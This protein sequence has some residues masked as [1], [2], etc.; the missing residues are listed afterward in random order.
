MSRPVNGGWDFVK[1]GEIYQYKESPMIA[2]VRVLEDNSD[3]EWYNFKVR[4]LKSTHDISSKEFTV[5]HVKDCPG[6][7]NEMQQF[8]EDEEYVVSRDGKYPYEYPEPA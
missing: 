8:Y 7:Y 5:G 2:M 1:A 6:I 3:D 4:V